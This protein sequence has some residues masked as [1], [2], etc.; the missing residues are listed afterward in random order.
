MR[1]GL[2]QDALEGVP[3][4]RGE[5]LRIA[6]GYIVYLLIFFGLG[7]PMVIFGDRSSPSQVA[8]AIGLNGLG[9]YYAIHAFLR[10][11]KR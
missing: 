10:C 6:V 3:K 7:I 9:I 5:R 2:F 1:K 11:R 4:A 8:T